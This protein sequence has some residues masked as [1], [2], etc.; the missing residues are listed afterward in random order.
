MPLVITAQILKSADQMKAG[1]TLVKCISAKETTVNG[2]T[3]SILDFEGLG[4]PG[5]SDEN[6]GRLITHFIY[7]AAITGE[8]AVPEVVADLIRMYAAFEECT[9]AE[10]KEA[11]SGQELEFGQW[12]GKKVYIDVVDHV[13]DGKAQKRIR[14]WSPASVVPF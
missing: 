7:H 6:A 8:R 12:N 5:N 3:S 13:Y 2:K 14:A 4:G 9:I 1:W 11:M 10:A